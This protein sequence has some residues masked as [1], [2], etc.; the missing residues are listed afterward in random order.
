MEFELGA[1]N[2]LHVGV[3]PERSVEAKRERSLRLKRLIDV[4]GSIILLVVF[5]PV[6]LIAA[7]LVRATSPGPVI[8]RQRRAGLHGAA[9]TLLKIRTMR[10]DPDERIAGASQANGSVF[11]KVDKDP[12]VTA[13]G[14]FLRKYSVDELPQ[15]V[16]VLRGEM[17]LVGPRPLVYPEYARFSAFGYRNHLRRLNVKPGLTGLWQINGRSNLSDSKSI[18]YDIAYVDNWSILLDLK[19]LCKTVPAVLSGVGA[20]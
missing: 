3:S 8:F 10:I 20:R 6:F 11:F 18:N 1:L 2:E 7:Y 15:L 9:F 16:N 4:I 5:L 17:S 19:I 14:A 13:V 12:R